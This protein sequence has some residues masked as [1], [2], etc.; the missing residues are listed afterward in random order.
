MIK[1]M[2]SY[3]AKR[4]QKNIEKIK[5]K[6]MQKYYT[7]LQYGATF[8]Q[9]IQQDLAK[10]GDNLNRHQRRRMQKTFKQGEL[11]KE[12]IDHYTGEVNRILKEVEKRLNP[13]KVV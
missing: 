3:L 10:T 5:L 6:K 2:K 12:L 11:S 13:S 1:K 8:I 7:Y 4:K 9:F